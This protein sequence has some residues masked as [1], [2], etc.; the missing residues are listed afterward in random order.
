MGYGFS[1]EVWGDYALFSRPELRVERYSYEVMT[2]SAARGILE[3]IFWKPAIRYVIDSIVVINEIQTV[4]VRR[5]E[6]KSKISARNVAAVINGAKNRLY[7]ATSSDIAQRA[8][9]ILKDVRYVINAHF[10]L[11][12]DAGESDTKEKFYNMILRRL[13]KGQCFYNPYFGT[14]EFPANF[15]LY[16]KDK[17]S[18]YIGTDKDFGL[19][20]YDMDYGDEILPCYFRA[21]MKD[22]VIN[23]SGSEVFR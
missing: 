13:E 15:K 6:V 22:G 5:N 7:I 1:I 20:L 10:E 9:N 8:S 3:A 23:V 2:P 4:N 14:K 16:E 11:T 18:F 12:E 21:A 17:Q 19:M